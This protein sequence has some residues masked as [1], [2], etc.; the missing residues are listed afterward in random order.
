M[1]IDLERKKLN[2]MRARLTFCLHPELMVKDPSKRLG[3]M[4]ADDILS[5]QWFGHL[6]LDA[7]AMDQVESPYIPTK[8]INAAPQRAIGSFADAG[9]KVMSEHHVETT[10]DRKAWRCHISPPCF[11]TPLHGYSHWLQPMK[12]MT[13][14][15]LQN[16]KQG[17][18]R[19]PVILL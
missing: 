14:S 4:G 11:E 7:L 6:D 13:H 8:D 3:C 12:S 17:Q 15:K 5:H 9:S 10:L 2:P 18:L 19:P 1:S 16:L